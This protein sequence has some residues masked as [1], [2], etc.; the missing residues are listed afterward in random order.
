MP[1]P[2]LPEITEEMAMEML[3]EAEKRIALYL[4]ENPLPDVLTKTQLLAIGYVKGLSDSFAVGT[5]VFKEV[6]KQDKLNQTN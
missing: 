5:G 4:V 3:H 2:K 1:R 6:E